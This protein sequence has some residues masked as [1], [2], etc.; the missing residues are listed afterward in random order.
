MSRA[1]HYSKWVFPHLHKPGNYTN[2]RTAS[3]LPLVQF[4]VHANVARREACKTFDVS[5]LRL[6]VP[7]RGV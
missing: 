2:T 6:F 4:I 7:Q 5:V 3:V 1:S